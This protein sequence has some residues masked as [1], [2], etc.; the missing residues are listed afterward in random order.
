MYLKNIELSNFRN[1]ENLNIEFVNGTNIIYGNNGK[2]KT[3]IL[4]AIYVSAITKSYRAQK[5]IEYINFNFESTRVNSCFSKEDINFNVEVFADKMGNKCIKEDGLKINKYTEFIGKFPIVLF[6]PE[7]MD[8]VK[9]A[10]KNRRKFL[11]ILISQISKKY[12]I[13]LSE[14]KKTINIKNSLLKSDREKI[15]LNYLKIINEKL[16]GQILEIVSRR[17]EYIEKLLVYAKEIQKKISKESEEL[18]LIYVTEFKDMNYEQILNT[19]N[20]SIDSDIFK[21]TST[22]GVGHD[23]FLVLVNGNEVS[24]Y[25]SQ[26]QNRT[27]MLALKIGE[28]K[29]LEKEKETL[30]IVLLDDVFSELDNERINF[31]L[32]YIKS[33]QTVITTTTI[34]NIRIDDAKI[35][36][37]HEL[38]K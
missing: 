34:E 5:D 12:V 21:K 25:G 7:D 26:G 33:F 36:D 28:A 20:N 38:A 13:T 31:L 14:Y 17:K 27:A 10:P 11:D 2:G 19:L 6:C 16:A 24:K 4:E 9:G 8:I 35:F 18:D 3:N 22:K 37:I 15:D 23:D 30:P 1:Y 32:E 29:L